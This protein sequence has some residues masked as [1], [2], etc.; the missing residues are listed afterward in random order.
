MKHAA[1]DFPIQIKQSNEFAEWKQGYTKEEY[2]LFANCLKNYWIEINAKQDNQHDLE[3]LPTCPITQDIPLIPVISPNGHVYEMTAIEEHLDL[4]WARVQRYIDSGQSAERIEEQSH[5]VCP[6]R[7]APFKK[8]D[9]SY[10]TDFARKMIRRLKA[11]KD[12]LEIDPEIDRFLQ[13][14]IRS[15]LKQYEQTDGRIQN[16]V[17]L[18]LT[19]DLARLGATD[20]QIERIMDAYDVSD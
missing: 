7:G 19:R 18:R 3:E 10:A 17:A 15:L 20:E 9:L 2:E 13:N 16:K 8:E 1:K 12:R 11:I 4:A 5:I 14:G 6:C